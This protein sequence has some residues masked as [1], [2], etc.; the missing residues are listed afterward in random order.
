MQKCP[1]L[2]LR[3]LP[4]IHTQIKICAAKER[5]TMGKLINEVL[6]NYIDSYDKQEGR[7]K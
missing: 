3:T 1:K 6:Q 7:K 4:E 5:K 2:V